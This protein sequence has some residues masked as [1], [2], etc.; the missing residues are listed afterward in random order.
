[1][2]ICRGAFAGVGLGVE[3]RGPVLGLGGAELAFV[4]A[5]DEGEEERADAMSETKRGSILSRWMTLKSRVRAGLRRRRAGEVGFDIDHVPLHVAAFDHGLEFAVVG[6]AVLHTVMPLALLNGSAQACFCASWVLPPQ[7]T[8][9]TLSA[10]IAAWPASSAVREQLRL[11]VCSTPFYALIVV[12]LSG[13]VVARLS[14][15]VGRFQV[16]GLILWYSKLCQ[17][18][19]LT[20]YLVLF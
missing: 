13:L 11:H 9:F 3:Q 6:R 19:C 5:E 18:L 4:V 8:K 12:F 14:G 2:A 15:A 17:A 1:L 10:A 20:V 16:A 7:L